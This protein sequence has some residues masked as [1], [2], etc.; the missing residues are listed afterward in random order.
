M[1]QLE[2][3]RESQQIFYRL[4][5][6]R[7]LKEETDKD[8]YYAYTGSERVAILVKEQAQIAACQVERY[9]STIYLIPNEENELLGFSK[10]QLQKILCKGNATLRDYYLS[11]FVILT[12]LLVC[13][14]G[15]GVSSKSKEFLRIGEFQN[16]IYERLKEGA[17][18]YSIE[19]QSKTGVAFSNM[20][21]AFNSLKSVDQS[22]SKAKTTKEGFL[23]GIFLFLQ[24]QGLIDYLEKDEMIKTTKK[25]DQFM[26]FNLL[27]R[28][29]YERIRK[30]L[31]EEID[32]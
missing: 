26:D 3:I 24:E 7:E 9:G 20:L 2:E 19:V 15:G 6:K 16:I 29:H 14:E 17:E 1:F 31:G 18:V 32:E 23:H 25:L 27:N 8:F 12:L 11:Q 13:Y 10:R 4:L 28:N 5:E 22:K 30:V 21:E